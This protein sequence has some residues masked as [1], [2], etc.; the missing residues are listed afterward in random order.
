MPDSLVFLYVPCPDDAVA[1]SLATQL[2]ER[3]L[4]ACANIIPGITSIYSWE[5]RVKEDSEV[6]L[7]L[8]TTAMNGRLARDVILGLHPYNCPCI[9]ELS[10]SSVNHAFGDWLKGQVQ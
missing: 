3:K 6:I 5:G 8:K 10:V 2:V 9:A 4:V 7:L 1:R